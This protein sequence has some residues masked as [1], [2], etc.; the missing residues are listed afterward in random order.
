MSF[1]RLI[2]HARAVHLIQAMV[3]RDR[4]PHALLITG[5]AGVGKTTL[6]ISI[7][8]AV[9][10][11]RAQPGEGP[12]GSCRSCDKIRRDIH[13]DV[14]KLEP[15]G[16]RRIVRIEHIRELRSKVALRPFEGRTKVF[17]IREADRMEDPAANALLKTLEEPPPDSLIILTAPEEMD[18]LPTIVSRC[19]RLGLAPLTLETI[20]DWLE[21]AR[22]IVGLQ[23]RFMALLSGGCLGRVIDLD[24]E[25]VWDKRQDLIKRLALLAGLHPAGAVDWA[26]EI[27]KSWTQRRKTLEKMAEADDDNTGAPTEWI[28]DL[29]L[30]ADNQ[31]SFFSLL[32]FWYRDLMVLASGVEQNHLLNTDVIE[33][34]ERVRAGQTPGAFL[35][36]LEEI[37]R[38]EEALNRMARPELVLENLFLNLA[39]IQ[40][41][42]IE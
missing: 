7:A 25:A 13:P 22:G 15:E 27:S 1:D 24:P 34:L 9:N 23:A 18:L 20:E 10:C 4:L 19:L 12:C 2:G 11:E 21:S 35:S 41:G 5:P 26:A 29:A 32:R 8:Q 36:A 30:D 14:V 37:D 28:E 16:R 39:G 6:A 3:A 33:D 40:G 38:A 31:T 17:L 42:Q